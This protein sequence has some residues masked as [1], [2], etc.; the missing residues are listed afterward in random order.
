MDWN[1]S[2]GIWCSSNFNWFISLFYIFYFFV[3]L[4]AEAVFAR[5]L[6]S[7]KDQRVAASKVLPGPSTTSSDLIKDKKAFIDHI[8]KVY[9][10]LVYSYVQLTHILLIPTFFLF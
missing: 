7:L 3:C 1:C 10:I 5:C 4:L 6:S 8:G 9:Y 2:I